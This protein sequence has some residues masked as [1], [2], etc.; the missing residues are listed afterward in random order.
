MRVNARER[1]RKKK[2]ERDRASVRTCFGFSF[3]CKYLYARFFSSCMYTVHVP[4]C[5]RFLLVCSFFY[6]CLATSHLIECKRTHE[7]CKRAREL[8]VFSVIVRS[9]VCVY[10]SLYLCRY[11]SMFVSISLHAYF[12]ISICQCLYSTLSTQGDLDFFA[13]LMR[14]CVRVCV[15]VCGY[16]CVCM[17]MCVYV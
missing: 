4:F 12:C 7:L 15:C 16:V 10:I 11:L 17:C 3:A 2:Q 5:K 9:C 1:A 6:F 8:F 13:T 14:L